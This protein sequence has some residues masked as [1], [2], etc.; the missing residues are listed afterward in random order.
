MGAQDIFSL[1]AIATQVAQNY[2]ST[3]DIT[4][5]KA[6]KWINRALLRMNEMGDWSWLMV[7]DAT[8][9]TV[10]GTESYTL[11]AG[12]KKIYA[13]YYQDTVRRKLKLVDDRRFREVFTYTVTPQ[14]TPC[15]YRLFGRSSSN[16]RRKVALYPIPNATLA[17]YY[18]YRREI[19]L[20]N[21]IETGSATLSNGVATKTVTL[22]N[23]Y[24]DND[25]DLS[26]IV[27]S[28]SSSD[29]AVTATVT[30]QAVG[31]FI[32]SLSPTPGTANYSIAYTLT[33]DPDVRIEC[34]MPDNLVD[35]L[36][37]LAT[38]ISFRELDD[39]DYE[40]A[41]AEAVARCRAL[42]AEDLNEIDDNIRMIPFDADS[43]YFA[44]P[45]L[46]PQYGD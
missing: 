31:S 40:N 9:N 23:T 25:Y 29:P 15:W 26:L 27:T 14:G 38:A 45:V 24:Y 7:F 41:M 46:P 18:D 21:D 12:V 37:E 28:S 30:S 3:D 33:R 42:L 6:K 10:S 35:C 32:V 44:D 22:A 4:I 5:A 8:F 19:P 17:M 1:S 34:G 13:L 36:I 20:L 43:A 16:G 39:S 2:G 11:G